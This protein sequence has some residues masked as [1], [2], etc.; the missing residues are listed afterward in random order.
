MEFN[1]VPFLLFIALVF[2]SVDR[3]NTIIVSRV[4]PPLLPFVIARKHRV[5]ANRSVL[6][7]LP[8]IRILLA[9]HYEH[10]SQGV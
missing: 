8:D 10:I 3:R 5:H 6:S 7:L 9:K 4:R 2:L 1:S